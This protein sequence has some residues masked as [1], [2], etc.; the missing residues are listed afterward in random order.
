MYLIHMRP[1][2]IRDAVRRH[3]PVLMPAGCVEYHGPHLPIGTDFLIANTVCEQVEQRI[4]CVVAPHLSFAPTLSWAAGPEEGEVDFDPEAF[5]LY[6][7]EAIRSIVAMGFRRV[8]I[9]QHHQGPD[10]LEVLC[11]K[12][13]AGE[14]LRDTVRGWGAGWGRRPTSELP[15]PNVFNWIRVAYVDSFSSYPSSG[16][17]RIPIGHG[18]RGET[19]LIMDALPETVRMAALDTLD[20]LPPWLEDADQADA[21]EGRRWIEFCVEG[22]AQELARGIIPAE[23]TS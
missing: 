12:R 11:L 6:A 4:E 22:W 9:L 8:Y 18:G 16:A 14:V 3:V 17:E 13:A 19:Q 23:P 7:R 10:G 5:F 20:E 1:E 15:I 21:T 2:Q